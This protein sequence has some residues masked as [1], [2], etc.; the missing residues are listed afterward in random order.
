[1]AAGELTKRLA[2][3]AV[4]IPI[5]VALVYLGGWWLAVLLAVAAAGSALEL[6]DMARK[7]DV[8]PFSTAGAAAAVLLVLLAASAG[9]PLRAAP[10]AWSLLVMLVL[11]AAIAAIWRR[12]PE[13]GPLEAVAV[14]VAGALLCGG[15]LSYGSYL[16]ALPAAL[17]PGVESAHALVAPGGWLGAALVGF[18]VVLTWVNDS[19]AYFGGLRFGRR[20]L[21]PRVSPGK[22]V[23]GA[24]AGL[25]GTVLVGTLY[26]AGLLGGTF[27]LPIGALAAAGGAVL[28][29]VGAQVGDLAESLFKRA[30]GVKDSGALLPG[31]GGLLD[32]LDALFVTLPLAYW[33]LAILLAGN[34]A[35]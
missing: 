13:R 25:V 4:G 1:M 30:A 9:T 22:T 15:T 3:A 21:I 24:L 6:F 5:A 27:G 23:E 35:R 34:A 33:Y 26:G 20:K 11:G 14:T 31:H 2:V 12:A 18:P 32:R 29:S 28:V 16:R 19:F 7:R 17:A 8:H 10:W